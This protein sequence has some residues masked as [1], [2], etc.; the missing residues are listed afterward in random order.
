MSEK[1]VKVFN[2][3]TLFLSFII[4]GGGMIFGMF[5]YQETILPKKIPAPEIIEKITEKEVI[6]YV[7]RS[8]TETTD[9]LLHLNPDVDP[10]LAKIIADTIDE[11]SEKYQ[12]PRKLVCSIIRKESNI[13]PFA[14][15]KVGAVGLMQVMPKIHAERYK[16]RNLWHIKTNIDVGCSIFRDYLD[17]ENGNMYKTF[18]RYLSKNATKD[19]INKYAGDIYENWA[20]LEMFD[21]LSIS[22]RSANANGKDKVMEEVPMEEELPETIIEKDEDNEKGIHIN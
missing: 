10:A 14:K 18:W 20:K 16:D 12:L 8:K 2:P 1:K 3:V 11:M 6:H 17:K 22:E 15:S 19:Q 21:Y 7:E 9:F 13:N 5:T 4:F